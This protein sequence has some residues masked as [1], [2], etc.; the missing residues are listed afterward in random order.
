MMNSGI[1]IAWTGIIKQA[2]IKI[3]SIS[4]PKNLILAKVYPAR[5]LKNKQNNTVTRVTIV[6][7]LNHMKKSV[8]LNIYR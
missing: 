8:F 5:E 2:N 7:F 6:L 4:R 1:I 3:N